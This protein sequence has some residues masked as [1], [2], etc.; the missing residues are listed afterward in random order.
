M[1]HNS[2]KTAILQLQITTAQGT[3]LKGQSVGR[4]GTTAPAGAGIPKSTHD[5]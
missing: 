4:L 3:V 1:I 5:D 2:S